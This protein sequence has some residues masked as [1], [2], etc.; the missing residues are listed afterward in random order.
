MHVLYKCLQR[1]QRKTKNKKKTK[2]KTK[3]IS[4]LLLP[5][6]SYHLLD[7][8]FF[9]FPPLSSSSSS[10]SFSSSFS[11]SLHSSSSSPSSPPIPFKNST[12]LSNSFCSFFFLVA[13]CALFLLPIPASMS[14]SSEETFLRSAGFF[15]GPSCLVGFTFFSVLFVVVGCWVA[16][17]ARFAAGVCFFVVVDFV[18]GCDV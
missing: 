11:S 7:L 13:L 18:V 3:N 6:L 4:I 1:L 16:D 2:T 12:S 5:L 14:S 15:F 9:F 17:A 8:L 10:S